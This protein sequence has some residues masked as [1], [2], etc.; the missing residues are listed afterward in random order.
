MLEKLNPLLRVV[1]LAL[2]GLIVYQLSQIFFKRD[3][4]TRG[5][6]ALAPIVAA[7]EKTTNVV[8]TNAVST[9]LVATN[10][11]STNLPTTNV[12]ASAPPAN[13]PAAVSLPPGGAP[14]AEAMIAARAARTRGGPPGGAMMM[15]PGG[16]MMAMGQGGPMMGMGG[17]GRPV[18]L[19]PEVQALVDK[20]RNSQILGMEM[21]PPPMAL[22]GIAGKDVF[23]RSPTG[24]TGIIREG[25]QLG[26]VKLLRIGINRVL[27]EFENQ[28]SELTIFS[29]FGSESLL[30]PKEGKK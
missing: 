26:G 11:V 8:S 5:N 15:G 22:L 19:P 17:P 1:C 10:A 24:Q 20:I 28:Q 6:L 9:N 13:M 23:L 27:V 25:E 18:S 14:N 4:L 2:A 3:A 7:K 16:P 21:K 12:A 29:G 30:S